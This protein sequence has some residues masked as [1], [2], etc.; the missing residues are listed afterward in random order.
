MAAP[1]SFTG[2]TAG[3]GAL[4][5]VVLGTP[6]TGQVLV[7]DGNEWTNANVTSATGGTVSSIGI[8]GGSSGMT[9]SNSPITSSGTMTMSGTLVVGSGGT[10]LTTLA[11][12]RIP[13]GAGTSPLASTDNLFY[14]SANNFLGVLNSTPQNVLHVGNGSTGLNNLAV[15]ESGDSIARISFKDSATTNRSSV[16]VGAMGDNMRLWSNDGTSAILD[17]N[18]NFSVAGS[19]RI[20]NTGTP[21]A[22]LHI[23]ATTSQVGFLTSTQPNAYFE[24]FDSTTSGLNYVNVGA[25]G[26]NLTFKSNNIGY[27]W[28]TADGSSGQFLRTDGSGNLSFATAGTMSDFLVTGDSGGNQTVRNNNILDIAGGTGISTVSTDSGVITVTVSL[29]NTAVSAGSYTNANITV[30]AQGRITAASN[31]SGGGGSLSIGDTITGAT[32]GSV[33]FAGS[34]GVLAQDNSNLFWEP[35]NRHLGLGTDSPIYALEVDGGTDDILAIFT[36][37][38][39]TSLIAF[40]DSSTTS[41]TT[42]GV[43]ATGDNLALRS[44]SVDF[45]MPTSDGSNGQVLSTD[46]SGNLSFTTA[47]GSGSPSVGSANQ[48]NVA[49]GSGG[50]DTASVYYHTNGS[51]GIKIGSS[52]L[53][54]YPVAATT[55]STN[56]YVGR[57]V[58]QGSQSKLAFVSSTTTSTSAAAIGTEN[59]RLL[60]VSNQT[61]YLFPSTDG[62]NGDVLTTDG[63]GN[64]SFTTAPVSGRTQFN[65]TSGTTNGQTVTISDSNVTDTN[66]IVF[67]LEGGTN[68][69][70]ADAY[71]SNRNGSSGEFTIRF[72]AVNSSG[73]TLGVFCNYMIL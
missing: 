72:N 39:A 40:R 14:D 17:S 47:S 70:F 28:A 50:W 67:S 65:V 51:G 18:R 6:V 5:T 60:F 32:V 3:I 7:W 44:G 38:D 43:G 63:S 64:L 42:V 69:S 48:F 61:D 25:T 41:S 46:G 35:T 73:F 21:V 16:G 49:D 27:R 31:G 52:S 59:Q 29:D 22:P 62:S 13:F 19:V 66:S 24:F 30:D 20:G 2:T 12:G 37:S 57:F 54:N 4:G 23:N 33:L 68:V 56:P 55:G 36:S 8:V 11:A 15:F 1:N 26:D 71:I 34:S 10:G 9:F 45:L 58:S 53:P